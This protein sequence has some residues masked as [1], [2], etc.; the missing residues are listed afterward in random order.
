LLLAYLS[1][2]REASASTNDLQAI[3][4]AGPRPHTLVRPLVSTRHSHAGGT[5]MRHESRRCTL[6]TIFALVLWWAGGQ[7]AALDAP[8]S[9]APT[10]TVNTSTP[11]FEWTHPDGAGGMMMKAEGTPVRRV[12]WFGTEALPTTGKGAELLEALKGAGIP[13]WVI[14]LP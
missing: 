5:A 2:V 12:I 4:A 3:G 10:G 14:K 8:T 1:I 6:V 7:A 13:Y 9:T 11:V